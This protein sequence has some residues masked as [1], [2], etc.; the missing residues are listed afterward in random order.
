MI[1]GLVA[2]NSPVIIVKVKVLVIQSFRFFVTPWTVACQAPLS[3]GFPR[4]E[5]W[6]G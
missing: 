2:V 1:P 3:M 4:P 6:N 5:Y